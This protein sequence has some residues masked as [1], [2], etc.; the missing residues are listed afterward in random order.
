MKEQE[1]KKVWDGLAAHVA[2]GEEAEE[3]LQAIF[4]D[5]G[6]YRHDSISDQTWSKVLRFVKFDDAE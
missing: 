6:P 1:A 3:L 5:M 2:R 4:L